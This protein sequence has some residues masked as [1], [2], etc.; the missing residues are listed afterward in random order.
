M[1]SSEYNKMDM[2]GKEHTLKTP[3]ETVKKTP[4]Q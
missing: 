3:K 4:Q 1:Q 2:K